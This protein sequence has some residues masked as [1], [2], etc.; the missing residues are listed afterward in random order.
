MVTCDVL[1]WLPVL[2]EASDAQAPAVLLDDVITDD[3]EHAE[4]DQGEGE[5]KAELQGRA[6]RPKP[7][8]TIHGEGSTL[9]THN[10]I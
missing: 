3:A 7:S 4:A 8:P 5:S 2:E 6:L 10:T 9:K 1:Q